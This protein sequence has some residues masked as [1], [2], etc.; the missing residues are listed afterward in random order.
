MQWTQE[1]QGRVQAW[2]RDTW[3][4]DCRLGHPGSDL[5]TVH[6]PDRRRNR[7][8]A[9][10]GCSLHPSVDAVQAAAA[11]SRRFLG[12]AEVRF[13]PQRSPACHRAARTDWAVSANHAAW[14][15]DYKGSPDWSPRYPQDYIGLQPGFIKRADIAWFASHHH[16][17]AGLNEPYE[18]S[19]L[20]AYALDLPPNARTLTFPN[21]GKIRIFAASV[22]NENPRCVIPVQP[23]YDTLKP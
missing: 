16:T 4:I 11:I 21:N 12:R 19:Y 6:R 13:S 17:A 18:Y 3:G 23:L 15:L 10:P 8:A 20:F 14:D 9:L 7:S 1:T 2:L 5:V 22:A